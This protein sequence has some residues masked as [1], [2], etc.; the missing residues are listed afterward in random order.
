I[1]NTGTISASNTLTVN[2]P[3]LTNQANQVNVGQIWSYIQDA[4]YQNTTG[5]VV[6]PGG[7]MSAANMDLNVQTLSQ[8]GGALQKLDADGTVDSAGTQQLTAA[9]QQQLGSNFTQMTLTDH[10]HTDFVKE[11]GSFGVEQLAM[12]VVAVAAAIAMQPEISAEIASVSGAADAA[13]DA[14]DE[15]VP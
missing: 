10:L 12:I 2:T 7:F 15:P 6:Q 3:T 4:G 14:D 5:T 11:G 13:A 9:L 8:I 1:L